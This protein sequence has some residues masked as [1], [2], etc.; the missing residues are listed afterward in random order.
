MDKK[1]EKQNVEGLDYSTIPKFMHG[2]LHPSEETLAEWDRL[3]EP[4]V[5]R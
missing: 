4:M 1:N 5:F 2:A 3:C